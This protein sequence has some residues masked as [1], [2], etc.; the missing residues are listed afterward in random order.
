MADGS[1]H[2]V[3]YSWKLAEVDPQGNRYLVI[4]EHV[5]IS[6]KILRIWTNFAGAE[7]LVHSRTTDANGLKWVKITAQRIAFLDRLSPR[8]EGSSAKAT[9]RFLIQTID[10]QPVF[11]AADPVRNISVN[12][13]SIKEYSKFI[14]QVYRLMATQVKMGAYA[15][16]LDW[17]E[18]RQAVCTIL[19]RED[20][21]Y[22]QYG[23]LIEPI[24]L[25]LNAYREAGNP[26]DLKAA[27]ILMIHKRASV[28]SVGNTERLLDAVRLGCDEAKRRFRV[29]ECTTILESN[30]SLS[31][32]NDANDQD[33]IVLPADGFREVQVLGEAE[34]C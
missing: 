22:F 30:N 32:P 7:N 23:C 11:T 1:Y 15:N 4:P 29:E 6:S 9:H 28:Y 5:A 16:Y 31:K 21:Y 18:R 25:R 20:S 2:I 14:N 13:S 19:D 3:N 33:R 12:K 10:D 17:A 26:E 24:S 27:A 34:V 8:I